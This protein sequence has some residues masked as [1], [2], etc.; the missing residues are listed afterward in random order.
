MSEA[1]NKQEP[2]AEEYNKD[3]AVLKK[4]IMIALVRTENGPAILVN[5]HGREEMIMA[6]GEIEQFLTMKLLQGDMRAE[7][8]RSQII[9]PQ[10]GGIIDFAR[11]KFK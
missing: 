3:T 9:K 1:E 4:E 7:K 2:I 6:K 10:G 8:A 5:I 11:K